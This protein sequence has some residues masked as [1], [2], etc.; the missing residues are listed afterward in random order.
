MKYALAYNK[1]HNLQSIGIDGTAEKLIQYA[2][3]NGNSR[4]KSVTY[5]NGDTMKATYNA[6]G[7]M[8]AEKWYN[9][10]NDVVAW[11]KYLYDGAGNL[12]RS[13]DILAKKEYTY[14]YEGGVIVAAT[15]SDVVLNGE[16]VTAKTVVNTI[17]YTYDADGQLTKKAIVP[18]NGKT[19]MIF[20]QQIQLVQAP[21]IT[22]DL[23]CLWYVKLLL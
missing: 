23:G 8:V 4:L 5:A 1:F 12:V 15:E 17:R 14:T 9:M 22:R 11:Y 2:Y 3:K 21:K 20:V 18:A 7:Q 19:Q 10:S 16:I 6:L 13:L